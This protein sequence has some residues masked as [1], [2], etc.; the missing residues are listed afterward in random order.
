MTINPMSLAQQAKVMADKT[1]KDRDVARKEQIAYQ[2]CLDDI[3][4]MANDGKYEI[5]F[6]F[7][8]SA[9]GWDMKR[10]FSQDGFI[11]DYKNIDNGRMEVKVKWT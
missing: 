4:I 6:Q 11:T 8:D 3:K 5:V 7:N 1:N 10:F 2:K 9:V